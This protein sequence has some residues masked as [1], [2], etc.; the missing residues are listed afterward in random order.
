MQ[1]YVGELNRK[2][3]D[4]L[5]WCNCS[6]IQV[7]TPFEPDR[8]LYRLNELLDSKATCAERD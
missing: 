4:Q 8:K 3:L 2:W 7:V 5:G 6:N 1:W